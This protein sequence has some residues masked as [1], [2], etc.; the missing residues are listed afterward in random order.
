MDEVEK[1]VNKP[2]DDIRFLE[3]TGYYVWVIS[4]PNG[5]GDFHFYGAET[6]STLAQARNEIEYLKKAKSFP[7]TP[8]ED[9][10][11]EGLPGR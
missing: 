8:L 10:H 9:S 11:F 4:K 7:M 1:D 3:R 5:N 2:I 6:G